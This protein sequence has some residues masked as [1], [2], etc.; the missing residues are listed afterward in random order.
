MERTKLIQ[1]KS[2]RLSAALI[3]LT[4]A[5]ASLGACANTQAASPSR[6]AYVPAAKPVPAYAGPKKTIA[7]AKFDAHGAFMSE[8]GGWD[9]GGGLAAQLATAL[10][11]SN[12]FLLVERAMLPN[13]LQE[14]ELAARGLTRKGTSPRGGQLIGAQLLIRG[15]VT[16]FNEDDSGGGFSIGA[17]IANG[18]SG[19]ISP[20]SESG[21]VTI[22]FRVIDT[23]TGQVVA[24]HT[25]VG[26][27]TNRSIAFAGSGNN[28][29]FEADAFQSTAL[30]QA[31]RAAIVDAV[32]Y[33]EASMRNV[34]WSAR[35]AKVSNGQVYLTAGSNAN[36]RPGTALSVY[37]ISDRV[38]DP[39]TG[40]VLGTEEFPVG[41]LVL[42][43]VEPRYARGSFLGDKMPRVGDIVRFTGGNQVI[44]GFHTR[45]NPNYQANADFN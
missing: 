20:R 35:V 2:L 19:G 40:E 45:P 27:I 24:T 31:T 3:G 11:K 10:S 18:F 21:H 37:A 6:N 5:V 4:F 25:S 34:A 39:M 43:N 33:I 7:V 8:Y 12:Q 1:M 9:V 38:I 13:V 29:D 32:R 42:E 23:T 28:F 14:Q 41:T 44:G 22:D 26:E 17:P 30:G 16:E 36:L 15:S